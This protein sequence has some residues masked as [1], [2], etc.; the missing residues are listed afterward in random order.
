MDPQDH[1]KSRAYT[2]L[3]RALE[4]VAT[5]ANDSRRINYA[6]HSTPV[7]LDPVPPNLKP[8]QSFYENP[9]SMK[10]VL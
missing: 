4:R 8:K 3:Y 1:T 10:L 5:L 9:K 7:V 2:Y 6:N